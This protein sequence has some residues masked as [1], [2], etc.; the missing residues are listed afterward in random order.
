MRTK[1]EAEYGEFQDDTSW[2]AH[3][4]DG[5]AGELVYLALG[6]S[7]ETGE[8][9]DAIKKIVRECGVNEVQAF[10]QILRREGVEEKLLDELG[11]TFWYLNKLL[12]FLNASHEDLMVRNTYKLYSRLM[13]RPKANLMELEWPFS[14]PELSFGVT[15]ERF[16]LL[17]DKT[18]DGV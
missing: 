2:Y 9:A 10:D 3:A 16:T 11:D 8:F 13:E 18:K 7:G 4:G 15:Q 14:T 12:R 17:K 5:D 1:T 6:L